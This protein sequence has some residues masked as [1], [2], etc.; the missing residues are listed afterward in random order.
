MNTIRIYFKYINATKIRK[1]LNLLE[2]RKREG[3]I[4]ELEMKT[5]FV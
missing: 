4:E 5:V 3:F 2:N 1:R